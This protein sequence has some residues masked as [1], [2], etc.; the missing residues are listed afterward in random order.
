M[1]VV[2][3]RISHRRSCAVLL[4]FKDVTRIYSYFNIDERQNLGTA[5]KVYQVICAAIQLINHSVQSPHHK[6][7]CQLAHMKVPVAYR[8][9]SLIV[10]S[11]ATLP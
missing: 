1:R 11:A 10:S 6:D 4:I 8:L 3:R 9:L 7:T 5:Q 2:V